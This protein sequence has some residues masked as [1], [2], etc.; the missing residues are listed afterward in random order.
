VID[1]IR[2]SRS[3]SA[4]GAALAI[5]LMSGCASTTLVNMWRDPNLPRQPLGNT[6]VVALQRDNASRRSWEDQFVA[7][8]KAHG[9]NATP[10]YPLFPDAAPDTSSLSAAFRG[11]SFDAVLVTH[12]LGSSTESR[13]VPGYLTPEP[14]TVVN[15]WTGHYYRYYADVYTPGHVEVSRVVRYETEVWMVRGRSRLIWTGTT[16]TIDPS[17]QTQMKKEISSVIVPELV[18][19]GVLVAH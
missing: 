3:I 1:G 16:E 9:I 6:L 17:S 11:G 18:K 7:S 10:S 13:Y 19:S 14:M 8:L 2:M 4:M 15:P 5:A 12:P